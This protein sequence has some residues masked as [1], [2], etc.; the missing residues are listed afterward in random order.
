MKRK[1]SLFALL[2]F[3]CTLLLGHTAAA[4]TIPD[5]VR[6]TIRLYDKKIY[7]PETEVKLRVGI[8]NGSESPFVF[9]VA[10]DKIYSLELAVKNLHNERL[11]STEEYIRRTHSNQ[12]VLY[13]EVRLLPGEEYAFM[14]S[15]SSYVDIEEPGVYFVRASLNPVM[16]GSGSLSSNEITLHVRPSETGEETPVTSR[17]TIEKREEE[18]LRRQNLTPDDVIRYMIDALIHEDWQR[19]FLYLD[20]ESLMLE[21]RLRRERYET[22]SEPER[23]SMIEDY[24][25]LLRSSMV[26][27]DILMRPSSYEVV[28]YRVNLRDREEATVTVLSRFTYPEYTEIKRF[29]YYLRRP[30][31][32]W[33]VYSYDVINEGT[34]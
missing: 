2:L 7:T 10:D 28:Q 18:V 32:Y 24:R 30:E 8:I 14:A 5:G 21:H 6:L 13:R 26:H 23:Q 9:H 4:L 33:K 20:V 12:Q 25:E 34:E 22:A 19:F 27:G 31:D 17:E 15:L 11:S 3:L 1:N 29:T 16:D